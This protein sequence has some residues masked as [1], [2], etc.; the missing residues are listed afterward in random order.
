M[1]RLTANI[2]HFFERFWTEVELIF[3]EY[4]RS[5]YYA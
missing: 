3:Y 1:K 5:T 4:Y 2:S